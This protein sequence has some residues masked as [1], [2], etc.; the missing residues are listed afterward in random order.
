MPS[1]LWTCCCVIR[2]GF[3]PLQPQSVELRTLATLVEQRRDLVNDR[4]RIT[5]RLRST[6][7]QYYP[8]VLEWF[9]RINTPLFLR[10]HHPL[11]DPGAS[12]ASTQEHAGTVLPSAQHELPTGS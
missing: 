8:Q 1:W 5:N 2:I 11:A 12:Q 10:L 4:V 3:Q 6:L 7:K 9:D